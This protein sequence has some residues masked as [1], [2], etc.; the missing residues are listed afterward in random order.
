MNL[1]ATCKIGV[2]A[3]GLCVSLPS[4]AGE[5][6]SVDGPNVRTMKHEDGSRTVFIR[7]P[8]SR[9]LTKKRFLNGEVTMITTYWLN[10]NGDPKGCKIQDGRNQELFK[11]SYGY[12][13]FN[14]VLEREI[15]FDSR[16]KRINPA[17]G[18]ELPVQIIAYVYD[19]EGKRSA[20]IV[21]N[22]LPGKKM[23]DVFGVKSSA[24]ERNPFNE[25]APPK[26]KR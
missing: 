22:L 1:L 15:M 13:K 20:P 5:L 11:V 26:R 3:A 17:D 23:E 14:G 2:L 19:A 6:E 21:Y 25:T 10:P 18:K 7:S 12:N 9:I 24:L 8:D 4:R 16:V